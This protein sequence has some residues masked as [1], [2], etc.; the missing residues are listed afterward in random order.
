MRANETLPL[1]AQADAAF[2]LKLARLSVEGINPLDGE[3]EGK[4]AQLR[5]TMETMRRAVIA[6]REH[7]G[8]KVVAVVA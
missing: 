1:T 3:S 6:H 4:K 5:R 7:K 8:E 2:L